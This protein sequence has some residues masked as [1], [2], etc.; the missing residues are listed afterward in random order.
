[1]PFYMRLYGYIVILIFFPN[2]SAA[3][4]GF[5]FRLADSAF[6]LTQ[7]KVVYDLSYFSITYPNGDVPRDRGVCTDVIIR[8]YRKLHI[9]LQQLVHE[10]MRNHFNQYPRAWGLNAPDKNIDHRRVPNLM[11]FFKRSGASLA[12]TANAADYQP[13]DIVCWSLSRGMKHI[14]MVV[15]Q[16]SADGKRQLIVH[17]IGSGQVMEDCLFDYPIIGHYRYTR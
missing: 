7:Q 8:A 10:D 5:H 9:D 1:M 6:T 4:P 15:K 16:K 13:G 11:T 2:S 14:G 12:V 17:N 3:Q